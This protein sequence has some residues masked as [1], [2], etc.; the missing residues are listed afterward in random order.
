MKSGA[1]AGG[2]QLVLNF[3]KSG[4]PEILSA[5]ADSGWPFS[6]SPAFTFL[7]VQKDYAP[8]FLFFCGPKMHHVILPAYKTGHPAK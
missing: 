1:E 6:N 3:L 5:A 8:A 2:I 7:T 4:K